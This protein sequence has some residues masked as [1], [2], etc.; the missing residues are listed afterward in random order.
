MTK[1]SSVA[2]VEKQ[3]QLDKGSAG[4]SRP[5]RKSN[6]LQDSLKMKKR[7]GPGGLAIAPRVLVGMADRPIKK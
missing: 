4:L 2:K 5:T 7:G 6:T 1:S 3:A